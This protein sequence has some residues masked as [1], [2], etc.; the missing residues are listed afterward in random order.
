MHMLEEGIKYVLNIILK[1]II[2]Q[3]HIDA[4]VLELTGGASIFHSLTMK[5]A[6]R[7][8]E[9]LKLYSKVFYFYLFFRDRG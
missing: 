4:F 5:N 9:S 8:R 1:Y 7:L 6:N 3:R 2:E